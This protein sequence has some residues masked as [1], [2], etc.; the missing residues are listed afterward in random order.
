[1]LCCPCACW[2]L[3]AEEAAASAVIGD[4]LCCCPCRSPE[5]AAADA[6]GVE[7][8]RL[9]CCGWWLAAADAIGVATTAA[10]GGLLL[11]CAAFFGG[12]LLGSAGRVALATTGPA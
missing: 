12:G 8:L 2:T 7:G 1:M 6:I 4:L 10:C 9:L 3:E 5:A 11:G